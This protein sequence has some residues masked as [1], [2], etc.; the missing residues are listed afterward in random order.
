MQNPFICV[1]GLDRVGKQ[2]STTLLQS[3][4]PNSVRLEFPDYSHW[5][6]Q[7]LRAIYNEECF[8]ITRY[9]DTYETDVDYIK[10][11]LYEHPEN[12]QSI[13]TTQECQ[14]QIIQL[15]HQCNRWS[16]QE[17]IAELLKTKIVITD[18]YN[19]DALAYGT[20][21]GCN[22]DWIK[23][24]LAGIIE[25]D[26]N[27]AMI[28]TPMSRANEKPDINERNEEYQAKVCRE[29]IKLSEKMPNRIKILDITPYQ[30]VDMLTS[31]YKVHIALMDMLNQ[32]Y[33]DLPDWEPLSKE[34]IAEVLKL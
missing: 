29:Y 34:R 19:L 25:T 10:Q 26:I 11:G 30:G 12:S 7:L 27:I 9:I 32:Y 3:A 18:R 23:A 1:T 16:A 14:P 17:K 33:L 20:V 6:G 22:P 13:V 2:T 31:I 21:D 24:I 4:I 28:G 8:E 15:L 5:S